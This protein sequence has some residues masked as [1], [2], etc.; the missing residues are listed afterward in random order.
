VSEDN[1]QFPSYPPDNRP[2]G[3]QFAERKQ[4]A[5]LFKAIKHVMKLGKIQK[6]VLQRR[7]RTVR[8]KFRVI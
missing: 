1:P 8:K 5:P 7:N 3:H 6:K 2:K 4:V